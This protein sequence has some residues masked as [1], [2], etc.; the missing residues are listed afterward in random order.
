VDL[1]TGQRVWFTPA[2]PRLCSGGTAERCY[3]G[4]GAA[5]SATPGVVF[6]GSLDGGLRAYASAD[7]ALLWQ[8]DTNRYFDTVNGVIARGATMDGPGPVVVDGTVYVNSGYNNFMGRAGNVL[9]AF[10]AQ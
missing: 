9:L 6:A 8:F 2:A 10:R 1:E 4:Q 5:V 3:A 7:G